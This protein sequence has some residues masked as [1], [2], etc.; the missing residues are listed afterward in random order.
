MKDKY[1]L[2]IF[3]IVLRKG[4]WRKINIY[5]KIGKKLKTLINLIY[6]NYYEKNITYD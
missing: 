2:L 3:G 4:K 1:D 6:Y 5:C